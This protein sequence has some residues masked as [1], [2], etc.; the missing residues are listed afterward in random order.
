MKLKL[1]KIGF[2]VWPRH[3]LFWTIFRWFWFTT[4]ATMVSMFIAYAVTVDPAD[5]I[6]ERRALFNELGRVGRSIASSNTLR[7]NEAVL[8]KESTYYLFDANNQ[9]SNRTVLS[10]AL[11]RIISTTVTGQTPHIVYKGGYLAVGPHAVVIDGRPYKLYLT[12]EMFSLIRW[13]A[14]EGFQRHWSMCLNALIVSFLLCILLARHLIGPIRQLQL[15]S[16]QLARGKFKS[17]V[18]KKVTARK[19]EL[20]ELGREFNHMAERLEAIVFS[21]EQLLR[22]V[23]HELRS[24][25]TRLQLSLALARKKAPQAENDH[26]RIEREIERLDHLIGHIIYCSRIQHT[27]DQVPFV[28]VQLSQ[29][30]GEVV[31][32]GDFEAQAHNKAV[33]LTVINDDELITYPDFLASAAENII[34]NAIRFTPEESTIEVTLSCSASHAV[35][36]IRDYGPG[37]P[38]A[39]L[40]ELFEPFFR[41][42]D[43]RGRENNGS[44]LGMA[45]A[46][47]VVQALH[48][49]IYAENV[50][51]GLQITIELPVDNGFVETEF[52]ES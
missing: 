35:I 19:D 51:P 2:F 14:Q 17:R 33:S 52:A 13:R 8:D 28:K 47:T 5:Y 27:M 21:N 12:K 49:R 26:A 22:D 43:T 36:T 40:S 42:D 45:I 10:K 44:G 34:R 4:I 29:L 3:S 50:N 31:K 9:Q 1:P 16:R 39:A 46:S 25:L 18:N 20:G 15:A 6:S 24:P 32:D 30:L 37:V 23:S 7:V 11:H 48:G 38:E 41:V